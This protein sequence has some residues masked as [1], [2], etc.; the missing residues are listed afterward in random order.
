ML[1]M[2]I[3]ITVKLRFW[4]AINAKDCDYANKPPC[5][6]QTLSEYSFVESSI[7]LP[8]FV[9]LGVDPI[10]VDLGGRNELFTRGDV[11]AH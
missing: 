5:L 7:E 9:Y 6:F 4:I 8:S 3:G 2:T 11:I 10:A 1:S